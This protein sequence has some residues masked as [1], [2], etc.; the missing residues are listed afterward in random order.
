VKRLERI[1]KPHELVLAANKTLA[2]DT[3]P[4]TEEQIEIIQETYAKDK[5]RVG[6]SQTTMSLQKVLE[7]N[8]E[9]KEE[10]KTSNFSFHCSSPERRMNQEFRPVQDAQVGVHRS[11][12]FRTTESAAQ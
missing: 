7:Y 8:E 4:P 11:S 5:R 3:K 9:E 6:H 10:E 12:S 2:M 1:E